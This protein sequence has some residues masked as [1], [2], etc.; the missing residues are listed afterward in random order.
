MGVITKNGDNIIDFDLF[1]EKYGC[2]KVDFKQQEGARYYLY[3]FRN[4]LAEWDFDKGELVL[5]THDENKVKEISLK[6]LTIHVGEFFC[7]ECFRKKDLEKLSNK[8]TSYW[9]HHIWE[10][11]P[12]Q[13]KELLQSEILYSINDMEWSMVKNITYDKSYVIFG[14]CSSC[15]THEEYDNNDVIQEKIKLVDNIWEELITEEMMNGPESLLEDILCDHIFVIEEG[16]SFIE[17][18]YRVGNGIIDIIAKDKNG[19]K[20]IIELKTVEDDKSLIW[21][22]AYYPSCFNEDVRM[23]TIA[24]N[25]SNRIYH[26]L[27]NINNVEMKVFGKGSNGKFD[28]KDFDSGES[29]LEITEESPI[30]V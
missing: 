15:M 12:L 4:D 20:C 26:A 11:T 23:I 19:T 18:Q 13:T 3:A 28:I 9:G 8:D 27:K 21:Q 29:V 25:Y 2:I 7:K 24:P 30:I 16:M 10:K 22:S 6:I 17:R 1:T 14:P 5:I